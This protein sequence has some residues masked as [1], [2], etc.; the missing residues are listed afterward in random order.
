LS[1]TTVQHLDLGGRALELRLSAA[2]QRQLTAGGEP[3]VVEMELYF[4][5]LIRKRVR[6]PAAPHPDATCVRAGEH[7]TVCFRPVM[8]RACAVE[9]VEGSPELEAFPIQRREA[10][11]PKWI[12]L[13]WRDGAWSGEFGF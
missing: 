8:T 11:L 4:S 7:M 2:A 1:Q 13:D 12:E 5:C 10:F 6:F 3:P 9:S